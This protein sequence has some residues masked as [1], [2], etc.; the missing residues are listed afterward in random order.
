MISLMTASITNSIRIR[1]ASVQSDLTMSLSKRIIMLLRRSTS[2][3]KTRIISCMTWAS[4]HC[5]SSADALLGQSFPQIS[6]SIRSRCTTSRDGSKRGVCSDH[7]T[8]V[9][10]SLT[11]QTKKLNLTRSSRQL[12]WQS[13]W[14]ISHMVHAQISSSHINGPIYCMRNSLIKVTRRL[15]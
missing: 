8:M 10:N 14:L 5:L 6:Q 13:K 7:S 11:P 9:T 4:L 12:R 3:S 1:W 2:C 15:Q